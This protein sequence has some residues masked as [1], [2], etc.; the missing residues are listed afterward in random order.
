MIRYE[1]TEMG[2]IDL[3]WLNRMRNAVETQ[4]KDF[5]VQLALCQTEI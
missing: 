4:L 3:H 2:P 5:A 1:Q